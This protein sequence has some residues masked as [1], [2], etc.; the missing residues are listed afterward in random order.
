MMHKIDFLVPGFSKCGTTTLC[1]LLSRHQ[2]IFISKRKEPNFFSSE[3]YGNSW[4]AYQ[5]LFSDSSG[6]QLLGEGSTSYTTHEFEKI[7]RERILT[8]YPDIKLIFIARDPLK[9]IESSYREYHHSG[10]RYGL[11]APYGLE[12]AFRQNPSILR[13]TCYWKR[14]CNYRDHMPEENIH[15]IFLEDLKSDPEGIMKSCF[16]FLGVDTTAQSGSIELQLNTASTKLYDTRILRK[17]RTSPSTGFKLAR[18]PVATQNMIFRALGLR[19]PFKRAIEWDKETLTE[20]GNT[21]REDNIQFLHHYGKT[22][23][24]WPGMQNFLSTKPS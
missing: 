20:T 9:R 6:G 16:E 3:D 17:L 1:A 5:A 12:A 14:I 23:E 2:D 19:R 8:H 7:A 11:D 22:Q 24:I 10:P 18:I 15:V 21:L 13:D 4:L